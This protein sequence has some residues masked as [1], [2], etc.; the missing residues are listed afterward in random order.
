MLKHLFILGMLIV[1]I[2]IGVDYS[3]ATPFIKNKSCTTG[4]DSS[5]KICLENKIKDATKEC[6][7]IFTYVYELQDN[8]QQKKL[9][10]EHQ[11]DWHR[12]VNS[13]I[14]YVISTSVNANKDALKIKN[15]NNFLKYKLN[16][17]EKR[18]KELKELNTGPVIGDE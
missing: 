6:E 15:Y 8:N 14:D 10:K 2:L 3:H 11:A 18:I 9:L 17:I 13:G 7:K 4:S 16:M 5:I 12:Y 1:M